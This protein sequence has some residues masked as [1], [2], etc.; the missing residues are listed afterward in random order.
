MFNSALQDQLNQLKAQGQLKVKYPAG[1]QKWKKK[2]DYWYSITKDVHQTLEI[3]YGH[4]GTADHSTGSIYRNS[5]LKA[6]DMVVKR[7]KR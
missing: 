6:S 4:G 7:T 3:I 1:Y 5:T 2:F